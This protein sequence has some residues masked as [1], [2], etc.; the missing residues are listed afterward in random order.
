MVQ[1]EGRETAGAEGHIIAEEEGQHNEEAASQVFAYRE[2][3]SMA[4][5]GRQNTMEEVRVVPEAGVG[6]YEGDALETE[7]EQNEEDTVHPA[8]RIFLGGS[9]TRGPGTGVEGPWRVADDGAPRDTVDLNRQRRPTLHQRAVERNLGQGGVAEAFWQVEW[10]EAETAIRR[11]LHRTSTVLVEQGDRFVEAESWD[12]SPAEVTRRL[13]LLARMVTQTFCNL[14]ARNS[15]ISRDVADLTVHYCR[16]ALANLEEVRHGNEERRRQAETAARF[17]EEVDTRLSNLQESIVRMSDQVRQS[18]GGMAEGTLKRVEERL[19]EVL[20]EDS[21]RRNRDRLQDEERRQKATRKEADAAERRKKEQQQ[22]EAR[23]QKEMREGMKEMKE[24]MMKEMKAEMKEMKD[25]MVNQI[26]GRLSAVLREESERQKKERQVD[27]ERRQQ[28]DAKRK[29]VADDEERHKRK[30]L[31]EQWRKEEEVKRKDV[32]ATERRR[33]NKHQE[34]ER[35]QKEV[36]AGMK[37]VMEAVKEMKTGIKGWKEGM[38]SEVEKRLSMVLRLDAERR[39]KEEQG[40]KATEGDRRQKEDAQ[41]KEAEE[42]KRVEREKQQEMAL[43]QKEEAQR[44]DAEEAERQEREKKQEMARLQ[45]EERQRKEAEEVERRQRAKQQELDRLQKEETQK[46]EAEEAERQQRANQQEMERLQKEEAHKKEVE[47]AERQQR[48]KQQEMERLQKEEAQKKEAEEAERQQRAK[49]QE[50]ERLQKEEA[51]K[52]AEEAE[53]QQRAKEQEMERLQKEEAQKKEAEEAERQHRAKQQEME[54]LQKEE[55]QKK[56]AEE[57]ERQ[58]RAKLQEMERL[59]KSEQ[60]RA[61]KRAR[62]A[63]YA[64]Q[65]RQLEAKAKAM[66]EETERLARE[67]EEEDLTMQGEGTWT[68]AEEEIAE[69]LGS[70]LLIESGEANVAE[71]V[72]S[73]PVRNVEVSRR[74]PRQED[75]EPEGHA[76]KRRRAAGIQELIP[77][78]QGEKKGMKIDKCDN[79]KNAAVDDKGKTLGVCLP[80]RGSGFSQRGEGAL[81][82]WTSEQT[83][84]GWKRNLGSHKT[85]WERAYT[86]AVCWKFYFPDIDM[87]AY[88]MNPNRINKWREDLDF[89]TWLPTRVWS[90]INELHLD[91]PDG[92]SLVQTNTALRQQQGDG[93]QVAACA[94]V[95]ITAWQKMTQWETGATTAARGTSTAI[96][97]SAARSSTAATASSAA[98]SSSAADVPSA[99]HNALATLAPSV[100]CVAVEAMRSV[101][102]QEHDK[103]AWIL[104]LSDA[105]LKALPA[106]SRAAEDAKR[107]TRVVAK[108]VTSWC[109][110]SMASR[111]LRQHQGV[112]LGVLQKKLGGRDTTTGADKEKKTK[113]SSAKG[114]ATKDASTEE[115]TGTGGQE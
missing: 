15:S 87:Q 83:V 69:G 7:E 40:R 113:K 8:V 55:A 21:E 19:R 28:Q 12:I 115:N 42:A 99:V 36:E 79:R 45:E 81:Q 101:K 35:R 22:E 98:S 88:G 60:C 33:K 80:F 90:V 108:V 72:A 50:M 61:E 71:G 29:Q 78:I 59:Q 17:R 48:A 58:Q 16:D 86:V 70:L 3:Q 20:R 92:F 107:M 46:K 94:G 37:E 68:G 100:A 66:A 18:G 82:K 67:M 1:A 110:C 30:Q 75:R 44:K 27:A 103:E 104:P 11:M 89:T 49:Q 2:T 95:G 54:R 63:S 57:A 93:F 76:A 114:N 51:Q 6:H 13:T 62:L 56:D 102:D 65:Q 4:E 26:V 25:G 5:T 106:E 97:S 34:E 85:V 53:R 47:E 77:I 73:V 109:L 84:G 23:W 32:E 38:L 52:E 111:G 43:L 105:L 14:A 10:V 74:R 9:P 39:Q 31:D 112:W 24:A 91:K 41:R 64:E 96:A